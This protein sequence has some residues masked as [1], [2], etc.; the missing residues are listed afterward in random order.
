MFDA[1]KIPSIPK[2]RIVSSYLNKVEE[3]SPLSFL[4]RL[5]SRVFKINVAKKYWI[6]VNATVDTVEHIKVRD[7]VRCDMG[8]R[9]VI[10]SIDRV[11]KKII[12]INTLPITKHR[13]NLR[14]NL[15]KCYSVFE[16]KHP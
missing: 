7:V 11:T 4:Q 8:D 15:I 9:Y 12:L 16:E 10:I 6:E 1:T 3:Y 13:F 5:V 14:G 2:T